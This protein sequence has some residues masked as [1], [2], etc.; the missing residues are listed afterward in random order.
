MKIEKI[1]KDKLKIILSIQELEKEKIDYQA[2]MSGS[3][4]CENI[5]T[6]LLYIAKDNLGFDTT[7]CRVEIETFELSH[8]NFILTITKFEKKLK[9]KRK[10]AN[11]ENNFCIYEFNNFN[12]YYDFIIFLKK[13]FYKLYTLFIKS[14][15][16]YPFYGKYILITNNSDFSKNDIK[17][18][19]SSITE[20]ATFKSNSE[21]LISKIKENCI[22]IQQK[23]HF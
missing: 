5:I 8:G 19:N 18:F 3:E 22:A 14:S 21:T 10:Q 6:E 4:K 2:F 1:S 7:N 12:N 16:I 13:Y 23:R 9:V 11:I 20:F 15:E 17:I